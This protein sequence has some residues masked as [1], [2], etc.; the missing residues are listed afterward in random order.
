MSPPKTLAS[1]RLAARGSQNLA[2]RFLGGRK[3]EARKGGQLGLGPPVPGKCGVLKREPPGVSGG[4][5]YRSKSSAAAACPPLFRI[6]V[7][8]AWYFLGRQNDSNSLVFFV[9]NERRYFKQD[10][11]ERAIAGLEFGRKNVLGFS[12][13]MLSSFPIS[14]LVDGRR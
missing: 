7:Y 8:S 10:R 9:K 3:P 11:G 2:P 5:L 14:E 4:E 6:S 1:R 13:A 12:L